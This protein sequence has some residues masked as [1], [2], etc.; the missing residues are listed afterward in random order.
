M[1]KSLLTLLLLLVCSVH[2]SMAY[3]YFTIYFSDGTKSEAFY[4]SDVESIAYSKTDLD[5][6]EHDHW[7]VQEIQTVDSLYR[8]PLASIKYL[9]FKE[10]DLNN[11]I[12][13]I[14]NACTA[15]TPIYAQCESID[16]IAQHL[17]EIKSAEGVEDAWISDQTLYVKIK[18][19]ETI[20][21]DFPP[22]DESFD[23]VFAQEALSQVREYAESEESGTSHHHYT[24]DIKNVCVI[25]QQY[26]DDSRD[27]R[28]D[29]ASN[30]INLCEDWGFT[31]KEENDASPAFFKEEICDYDFVF[32]MTHGKYEEKSKLHWILTGEELYVAKEDGTVDKKVIK[33]KV[34]KI[35]EDKYKEL[36]K[37]NEKL[38]NEG[39]A[40]YLSFH[41]IPEKRGKSNVKV[42]VYYPKISDKWIAS[43]SKQFKQKGKALIFNTACR[44]L[45]GN[46]SF[47]QAFFKRGAGSYL[48]YD[49]ESNGGYV[50]GN[51]F[52][53]GLLNG[54][55]SFVSYLSIP[56]KFRESFKDKIILRYKTN[57]DYKYDICLTK[58][59]TKD[60]VYEGGLAKYN[61][62][63]TMRSFKPSSKYLEDNSCNIEAVYKNKY[64]F[65]Y[66]KNPDMTDAKKIPV[67]IKSDDISDNH[68]NW[69][70]EI[71]EQELQPNTI[72]YY[73]AYMNDGMYDCYGEIKQFT[74]T[75]QAKAYFVY[76]ETSKT[77][78]LFFDGKCVSRKGMS[79]E[80]DY[81]VRD[82]V[83]KV[84][85]DSS[86][87]QYHIEDCSSLFKGYTELVT[88]ENL[89]FLNTSN[90]TTMCNMFNGCRSLTNLYLS[91]L[92]T[93][94]VTDMSNMFKGCSSLKNLDL[95]GIN[96]EKVK[97]MSYM[98]WGC[99]SLENLNLSGFK[100]ADV[101]N[102]RYMFDNCSSL[103]NLD[104]SGFKTTEVTD[105]SIMFN[106]CS[107]LKN[108]DLSSFKPTKVTDISFM[109]WDCSSLTNLNLSGF[110]T[111]NVTNMRG[112]FNGCSSLT[113][114]DL[115]GFIAEKVKSLSSMFY[116]CSSLTSLDLSGFKPDKMT[117]MDDM[118]G[119]CSSLKT[120]YAENWTI[121]TG[122]SAN[123]QGMFWNC[124]NLV[125][126]KGTKQG[127][128]AY[129]YD[130]NGYLIEVY[131]SNDRQA[132]HID[133][134]KDWPG[135]FT[136]K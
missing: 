127:W 34:Q 111:S 18:D 102:M 84:V 54:K 28:K 71:E 83:E 23:G 31:V 82:R 48:G 3:E 8:Y 66:S 11:V 6:I 38:S 30:F 136:K 52:L 2:R 110:D 73:R 121:K 26:R 10:V 129:G 135:L 21:Y 118:F 64:G 130:E 49:D 70:A 131:C 58:P 27:N 24:K 36:F 67:D 97:D 100:T 5:G 44:S 124:N 33:S 105:M 7:L 76:D 113:N 80:F 133:G 53:A 94:K 101:T 32:L 29:A 85:F 74:T 41:S 57:P 16:D 42:R 68:V 123:S 89:Q 55:S 79:L 99:S 106:G 19:W 75:E 96:A 14:A 37:E 13:D 90:A 93:D 45:M 91:G 120:I 72:Y 69:D 9:D 103:T 4:A 119:N 95:S 46:D 60:Y 98:F 61:L 132:A 22:E 122:S 112:M 108:L 128:N 109:F 25:N 39:L 43:G 115:S 107:S 78:T 40:N 35:F 104:L 126:G 116:G 50:A 87:A 63:G 65:L 51:A 20:T 92:N 15:I 88:I 117:G 114:L 17:S 86:F 59:E 56:K 47:A 81:K 77:M 1:K 62:Q 125:G 12:D 134:G